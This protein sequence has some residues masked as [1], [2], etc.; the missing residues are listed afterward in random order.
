M[1]GNQLRKKYL[2]FFKD[3]GHIVIPSASLVPEND[4]TTLFT[5]SGMQPMMPYLL[6]ATHPLGTRLVD[7]QKCFRSQDIEEVG[8]NRHTTFFEMLGNWSLGDYFKKEQIT[9]IFTFLTEELGL[10][11]E[12]LA[13]SIFEGNSD[14]PRDEQAYQLWLDLGIPKDRIF[15]YGVKKNW[16]SRSGTPDQMPSGEPGGPDSE[17]FFEFTEIEHDSK[18]GETCHPNC[19]C[20]RFLEIGNSVFMKYQ[21]QTDGSFINLPKN[22][23]DFGGGLERM[24]AAVHNDPDMFNTDL[25]LSAKKILEEVNISGT[26]ENIRII[27][28]HLKAAT[29]IIDAQIEPSNKTEGYVLRRLIRRAAVHSKIANIDFQPTFSLIVSEYIRLYSS[30]YPSLSI[31]KQKIILTIGTELDKFEATLQNGLKLIGKVSSFDLYQTYGFPQEI[32]QELTEKAGLTFD[33]QEFELEKQ[34]HQNLSRS[35]SKGMFKGGLADHSET[36][37]KYHTAT[38]LIHQSLRQILGDHVQQVG[39]NITGQR[40]RFDFIHPAALTDEELKLVEDLVNQQIKANQPVTK[41]ET[42]YEEAKKSGAL[43]FF[44][45]RYP[46]RVTVYSIDSFSK[47]VCGGPHVLNTGEIGGIKIY[48]QESVGSGRRRL[49]ARLKS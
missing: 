24:L 19:D 45:Q 31:N 44:G 1:T 41:T 25:F 49:Y 27:L 34:K 16:W 15:A 42:S 40:L 35:T 38:H 30:T 48:K 11:K 13:V 14:I 46:T 17:V 37:T 7:S 32:I 39:S 3:K 22:N 36:T 12:K 5:S 2:D 4:P 8:D 47:E 43:A 33:P 21:K 29:F 10:S 20:G 28:D 23:I 26:V 6:G 18:F 9:W